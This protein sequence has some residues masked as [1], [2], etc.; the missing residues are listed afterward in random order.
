[1]KQVISRFRKRLHRGYEHRAWQTISFE[2]G[3]RET[4]ALLALLQSEGRNPV[5]GPSR[6]ITEQIMRQTAGL[7]REDA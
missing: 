3:P 5:W 7:S 4:A 2:A 6:S 1:M